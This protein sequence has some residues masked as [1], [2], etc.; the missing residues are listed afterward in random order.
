MPAG[1]AVDGDT[2]PEIYGESCTYP[3]GNVYADGV[4]W[5]VEFG[6]TYVIEKVKVYT[7]IRYRGK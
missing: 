2:T 3:S 5:K 4:W 6:D 1:N 7:H